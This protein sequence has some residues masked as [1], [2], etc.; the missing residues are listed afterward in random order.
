MP[1]LT[2]TGYRYN[3][4]D[5]CKCLGCGKQEQY[6]NCADIEISPTEGWPKGESTL[7]GSGR[8]ADGRRPGYKRT[9]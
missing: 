4:D 5:T 3:G 8:Y 9:G 1:S 7:K 6:V 2:S